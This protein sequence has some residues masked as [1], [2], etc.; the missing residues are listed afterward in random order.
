MNL[1]VRQHGESLQ[2]GFRRGAEGGRGI[3]VILAVLAFFSGEDGDGQAHLRNGELHQND[4]RPD[5]LALFLFLI[6]AQK[7]RKMPQQIFHQCRLAG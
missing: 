7:L 4:I 1:H 2:Q 6:V 3:G 5:R